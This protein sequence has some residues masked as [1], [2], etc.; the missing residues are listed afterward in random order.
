MLNPGDAPFRGVV[1]GLQKNEQKMKFNNMRVATKLW[2][3]ILGLLFAMLLVAMWTRYNTSSANNAAQAEIEQIQDRVVS[4]TRWRGMVETAVTMSVAGAVTTDADLATQYEEKVKA[5][6]GRMSKLFGEIKEASTLDDDKKA[7]E[8]IGTA[9]QPLLASLTKTK[10]LRAAGDAAATKA[11]VDQTFLPAAATYLASIDD[12]VALQ[13]Q[14]RSES[15]TRGAAMEAR[16]DML[17]IAA[18]AILFALGVFLAIALVRS[19]TQPLQRAVGVT[20]AIAAGDLTQDLQDYRQDEFGDLLRSLSAM[21]V[22]L[23]GVVSEVRL[24]VDSVSTASNEI[25][26]GNHDLSERTEQTA[27]NL[28]QTAASMEELTSTVTQSADT[29]RQANQLASTAAQAATRGG[30]VVAQVVSTMHNIS[31]ASHKISEIIGTIDGIAFQTNILALNAAV[32]AAR[33]GEQG[34][35]FAVVASEVRSLAQRSA[36]AAKEIKVLIGASVAT[37]ESGTQQVAQA[38]E[39]M[40]EIV[41]SVRRVSDLIGEISASSGEQRDG[42]NQ[43]NQAV[44]NLDQM[45]QQNAALV[46]ESAAAAS[47]LREQSQR[48]AEVVSI[49]NVGS[50]A[51]AGGRAASLPLRH[52]PA[53]RTAAAPVPKSAVSAPARAALKAPAKAAAKAPAKPAAKAPIRAPMKALAPASK[54]A[55]APGGEG[56]WE[57]F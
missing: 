36:Q 33:A 52:A 38:G 54:P 27:S 43:V 37:V 3:V 22:K 14:H 39:T 42:I 18:V 21:V 4:S 32:E 6:S 11:Y 24:G 16:S 35:G 45:T 10:E 51:A 19:I 30:E 17:G 12:F 50:H 29:A 25:A 31:S 26:T 28:Q 23:R 2:A 44:A 47:G 20:E 41:S 34:R 55:A 15:K 9:R 13:V 8:K 40:G 7:L 1:S 57:S 48:L 53:S 49:F 46:E 5:L 56:E